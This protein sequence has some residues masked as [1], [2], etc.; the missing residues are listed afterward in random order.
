ME[1]EAWWAVALRA[2]TGSVRLE[3][4]SLE[5]RIAEMEAEKA[6]GSLRL[7]FLSGVRFGFFDE[8]EELSESEGEIS[9]SEVGGD[10]VGRSFESRLGGWAS[11]PAS[12]SGPESAR[13]TGANSSAEGEGLE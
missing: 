13:S 8:A 9:E 6:V 4:E 11:D 7:R 10:A 1:C 5:F 2:R 3:V 12:D